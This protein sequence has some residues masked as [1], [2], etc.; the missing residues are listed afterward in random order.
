MTPLGIFRRRKKVVKEKVVKE[1]AEKTLLDELCG[2]DAQL[3]NVLIR[4]LLLNPKM[5]AESGE[6]DS[7]AE[8]AQGYEKNKDYLR[9]RVEYQV[10]GELALYEGKLA[11]VQKFFKKAAEID[12]EYR[13]RGVFEFFTKKE[14]AEKA[15][16]VAQEYYART[17]KSE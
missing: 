16:A 6:I 3:K 15:L 17:A 2:D 8:K 12:S 5:T 9:A 7:R 4:T 14:N 1:A 11:Q 13:Q 10:A